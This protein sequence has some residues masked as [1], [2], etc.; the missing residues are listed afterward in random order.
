MKTIK[1]ESTIEFEIKKSRF[2]GY[3]KPIFTKA[4]AEDFINL[5]KSKHPDARHN[6]S[7]YKV[8]ENNF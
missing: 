5:I 7:A 6:C 8:L 3:I 1:K 4:E 2:I